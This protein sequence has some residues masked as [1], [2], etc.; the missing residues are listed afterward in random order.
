MAFPDELKHPP[1]HARE[2]RAA[3]VTERLSALKSAADALGMGMLCAA[4]YAPGARLMWC[5]ST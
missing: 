2:A 5:H 1:A 3:L 4:K